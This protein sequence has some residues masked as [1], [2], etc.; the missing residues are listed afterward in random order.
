MKP[1]KGVRSFFASGCAWFGV[2]LVVHLAVPSLT[3]KYILSKSVSISVI[4]S[5]LDKLSNSGGEKYIRKEFEYS[6][7]F[8]HLHVVKQ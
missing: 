6:K 2:W 3:I 7:Y 5:D 8:P 4:W 1:W